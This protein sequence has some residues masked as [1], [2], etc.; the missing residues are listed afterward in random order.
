MTIVNKHCLCLGGSQRKI[1][2]PSPRSTEPVRCKFQR[3]RAAALEAIC[4]SAGTRYLE[5]RRSHFSA[6]NEG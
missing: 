5:S 6:T 4:T 3:T 2:V 1:D